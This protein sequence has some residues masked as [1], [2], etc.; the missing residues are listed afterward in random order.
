MRTPYDNNATALARRF[1]AAFREAEKTG[2]TIDECGRMDVM[3]DFAT[4][5]I[6]E[7]LAEE[8]GAEA[9]DGAI[10]FGSERSPSSYYATVNT[11]GVDVF[12]YDV[13]VAEELPYDA[14]AIAAAVRDGAEIY[15]R[16]R[17]AHLASHLEA[18]GFR[19]AAAGRPGRLLILDNEGAYAAIDV[20]EEGP[21]G[22][23]DVHYYDEAQGLADAVTTTT[24][25]V[26]DAEA[27]AEELKLH[28]AAARGGAR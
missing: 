26:H 4:Y 12:Y 5:V 25:P 15:R 2:D 24:I 28:H 14:E 8:L 21:D 6:A 17:A 1:L 19:T 20:H 22:S 7:S 16:E 18:R 13:Q 23:V 10:M 3:A 11:R 27:I 9:D